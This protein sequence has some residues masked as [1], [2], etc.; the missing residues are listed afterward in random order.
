MY[1]GPWR[2][3]DSVKPPEARV[4]GGSKPPSVGAGIWTWVLEK[5]EALLMAKPS[6][7]SQN[8][9]LLMG[10]ESELDVSEGFL[11]DVMSEFV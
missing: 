6:L 3:Q 7:Q 4:L 8:W 1:G 5:Q 9:L 11:E 2:P 10:E